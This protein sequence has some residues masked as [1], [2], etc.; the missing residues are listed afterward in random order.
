MTDKPAIR[1]P[2]CGCFDRH[3]RE[4]KQQAAYFGVQ[5]ANDIAISLDEGHVCLPAWPY[6]VGVILSVLGAT[7]VGRRCNFEKDGS[8]PETLAE[9]YAAIDDMAQHAKE[10][11]A[12]SGGFIKA[13]VSEGFPVPNE[14]FGIGTKH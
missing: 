3:P 12:N 6:H 13:T 11:L 1:L 7:L 9:M 2:D 14:P 8:S 4:M 5:V 10:Q